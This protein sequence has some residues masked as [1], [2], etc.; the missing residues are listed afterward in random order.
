MND[1][2]LA[3]YS[4]GRLQAFSLYK[5]IERGRRS[6]YAVQINKTASAIS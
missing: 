2:L 6:V 4:N 1:R 5:Q 3:V